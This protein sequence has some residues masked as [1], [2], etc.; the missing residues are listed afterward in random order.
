MKRKTYKTASGTVLHRDG[1]HVQV[2]TG[3][4]EKLNPDFKTS[5]EK[6]KVW[7]VLCPDCGGVMAE[8]EDYRVL[9][10]QTHTCDGPHDEDLTFIVSSKDIMLKREIVHNKLVRDNIPEIIRGNGAECVT[11]IAKNDE[12]EKLL[13]DKLREEANELIQSPCAEE[14]ADVLEVIESIARLKGISIDEIKAIKTKKKAQNGSFN[15]RIVLE[16]TTPDR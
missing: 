5:G 16:S 10:G 2:E 6:P 1:S 3:N 12:Y 14:I 15:K 8:G 11:H 9:L 7:M 13:Y 4:T